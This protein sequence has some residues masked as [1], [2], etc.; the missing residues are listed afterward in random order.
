MK[1]AILSYKKSGWY[2]LA[3][4]I[5]SPPLLLLIIIIIKVCRL[6]L[7]IHPYKLSLLASRLDGIQCS[8]RAD[9]Y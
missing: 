1:Q 7:A 3:Q 9:K 4:K 2:L 6:S 5:S 8:H